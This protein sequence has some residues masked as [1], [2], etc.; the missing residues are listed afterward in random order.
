[1]LVKDATACGL[2]RYSPFPDRDW[3]EHCAASQIMPLLSGDPDL[4]LPRKRDKQ[5]LLRLCIK[6]R[7]SPRSLH[8]DKQAIGT[9]T[10]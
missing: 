8:G 6:M 9:T 10:V 2:R 5:T 4:P 1:M 3:L 7:H